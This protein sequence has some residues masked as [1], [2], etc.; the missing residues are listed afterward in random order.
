MLC[1]KDK[2]VTLQKRW[3]LGT[4]Y[5][6]HKPISCIFFIVCKLLSYTVICMCIFMCNVVLKKWYRTLI[7]VAVAITVLF[8]IM[9]LI[10]IIYVNINGE[11]NT[12]YILN[13]IT[14]SCK[15]VSCHVSP[16]YVHVPRVCKSRLLQSIHGT[17]EGQPARNSCLPFAW[18]LVCSA[19]TFFHIEI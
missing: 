11:Y 10:M 8:F 16:L 17:D 2:E 3:A 7:A 19:H 15:I 6:Y 4:N 14:L 13:T 12:C 5:N 9:W 18:L 1:I